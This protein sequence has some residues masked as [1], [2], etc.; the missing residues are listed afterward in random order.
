[1]ITYL[2]LDSL[3]P[4]PWLGSFFNSEV[5]SFYNLGNLGH[6]LQMATGSPPQ[7][8][9]MESSFRSRSYSFELWTPAHLIHFFG[10]LQTSEEVYQVS[11]EFKT[12][13]QVR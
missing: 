2:S 6:P 1:M 3:V 9:Q 8:I 11:E 13:L 12:E 4:I 5:C 10:S 7:Y